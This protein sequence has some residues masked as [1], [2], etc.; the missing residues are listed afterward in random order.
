MRKLSFV[1]PCYNEQDNVVPFYNEVKNR[2]T[3]TEF[4]NNYEIIFV[5]DGSKDKT[6][7]RLKEIYDNDKEHVVVVNFLHNFGKEAALLAGLRNISGDFV[8][9]IDSDCQQDPKYAVEMATILINNDGVDM[10]AAKPSNERNTHE[11]S[12]SGRL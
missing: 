6:Y 3:G 2:L 11:S 10:V 12:N 4:E 7:E 5:N 8:C 9:T 1:T